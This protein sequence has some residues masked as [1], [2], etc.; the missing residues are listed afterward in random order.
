MKCRSILQETEVKNLRI[1]MHLL[2]GLFLWWL[3]V[4][5]KFKLWLQAQPGFIPRTSDS[6][7]VVWKD[8]FSDKAV[9]SINFPVQVLVCVPGRKKCENYLKSL[10]DGI[11]KK[12]A[13]FCACYLEVIFIIE[14]K[15][16][17]RR[18]WMISLS[19]SYKF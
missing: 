9:G 4:F 17:F 5:G 15:V 18:E 8:K 1:L 12:L 6:G 14:S 13:W 7:K 3:E 10:Q 16:V 11:L 2:Q 19:I